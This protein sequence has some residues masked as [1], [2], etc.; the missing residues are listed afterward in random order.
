MVRGRKRDL[1]VRDTAH[2]R[3]AHRRQFGRDVAGVVA[4][5]ANR[6]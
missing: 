4:T 3:I 5:R 2:G 6:T 1:S